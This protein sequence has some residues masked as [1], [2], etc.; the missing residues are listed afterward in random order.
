[1]TPAS[2]V[3]IV[4]LYCKSL[5]LLLI[6][7]QNDPDPFLNLDLNKCHIHFSQLMPLTEKDAIHI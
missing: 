4:S 5:T 2:D 7:K 1:M 6:L 3:T